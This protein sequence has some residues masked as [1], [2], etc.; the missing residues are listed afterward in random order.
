MADNQ[1]AMNF[2]ENKV[3]KI[4]I[5]DLLGAPVDAIVNPA[6]SGLSHGGGIAAIISNE[7]GPQIDKHCAK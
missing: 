7:G 1:F 3:F 6:N 2:S 5:R 4:G